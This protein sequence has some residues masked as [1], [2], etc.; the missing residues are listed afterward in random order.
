MSLSHLTKILVLCLVGW[1]VSCSDDKAERKTTDHSQE[2]DAF[3]MTDEPLFLAPR[4]DDLKGLLQVDDPAM[5]IDYVSSTDIFFND[6]SPDQ[7]N[8]SNPHNFVSLQRWILQDEVSFS[9]KYDALILKVRLKD[10]GLE[11]KVETYRFIDKYISYRCDKDDLRQYHGM[12]VTNFNE[13][14][15]ALGGTLCPNST[16]QHRILETETLKYF[17][18]DG[19]LIKEYFSRG[20]MMPDS[21]FCS[22]K[23]VDPKT[24]SKTCGQFFHQYRVTRVD[25]KPK[26][27]HFIY[28]K[29]LVRDAIYQANMRYFKSGEFAFQLNN[30]SGYAEYEATGMHP[31]LYVGDKNTNKAYKVEL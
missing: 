15:K 22:K 30:W 26:T 9:E 20:E 10:L 8:N 3:R 19:T 2:E 25:D 28:Y 31:T 7:P 4:L 23:I 13:Q 29:S 12:T 27:D 17:D 1:L 16:L 6:L 18:E 11:S 5:V 14:I 21:G 24:I